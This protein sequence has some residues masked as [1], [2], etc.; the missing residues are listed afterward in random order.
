M[1]KASRKQWFDYLWIATILYFILGFFNI[2]FAWLGLICFAVP[3]LISASGKGKTYCNHY[4]GRGQLLTILGSKYKLSRNKSVPKWI[5]SPWFR[6]GFL[7]FFMLMFMSM[8]VTTY[9]V[10]SDMQSLKEVVKL[11]WIWNVPWNWA[12]RGGLA[13][14]LAQFAFGF[15]SIMLTSTLLGMITMVLYRPRTWCVYCP[16]GTMTQLIS[17]GKK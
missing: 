5:S 11:F 10:F 1:S 4:C 17:K 3:L 9:F 7:A 6:Y 15:Y 13:P 12:Y 8:I 16:M 14:W 2:L